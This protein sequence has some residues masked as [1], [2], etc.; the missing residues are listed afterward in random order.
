[1]SESPIAVIR[2]LA[3]ELRDI[4]QSD[5]RNEFNINVEKDC[6]THWTAVIIGPSDTPYSDGKFLVDILFSSEYP[7]TP[8][9]VTFRT[10]IFHPNIST[11]GAICLDILK[12][13]SGTWS[14]LMTVPMLL[15]SVQS[16][17]ADPNPDDPLNLVAS[18]LYLKNI[19]GFN[20]QARSE[21]VRH[22]ITSHQTAYSSTDPFSY[23]QTNREGAFVDEDAAVELAVSNSMR[24]R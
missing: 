5:Y 6:L 15:L 3:G 17:L 19:D 8:P 23:L 20:V 22:A 11:S 14:P 1:M 7:F 13:R 21:T 4:E 18:E 10:P 16:L 12:A 9:K 2:R 24:K